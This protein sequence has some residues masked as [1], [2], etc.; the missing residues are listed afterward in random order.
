MISY[1]SNA[2]APIDQGQ[3]IMLLCYDDCQIMLCVFKFGRGDILCIM[4]NCGHQKE[5]MKAMNLHK[6]VTE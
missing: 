2:N 5:G 4:L 6:K 1:N 3:L